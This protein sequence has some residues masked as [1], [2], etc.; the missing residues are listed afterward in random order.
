MD[1]ISN[2]TPADETETGLASGET[3]N[4]NGETPETETPELTPAEMRK[5]IDRLTK[6]LSRANSEAKENRLAKQELEERKKAEMSELE[7]TKAEY[8]ELQSKHADSVRES[9]E[10]LVSAEI[11]LA[12]IAANVDPKQIKL[13]ERGIDWSEIQYDNGQPTN[14]EALVKNLI[15]ETGLDKRTQGQ[16][17]AGNGPNP[18]PQAGTPETTR[19]NFINNMRRSGKYGV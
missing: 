1:N 18:K 14:I 3:P 13:I 8:A 11:R 2:T 19:Q 9:Q 6:S 5:M 15:K 4:G 12:A 7:R 17:A 10:R 16:S